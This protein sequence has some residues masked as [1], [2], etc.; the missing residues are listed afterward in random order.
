MS[1]D[2]L[3]ERRL[4]P[5]VV[6]LRLNRPQKKNALSI[7]LRDQISDTL[8]RLA[9]DESVSVVVFAAQG[10]T[11]SSG[12]DLGEF[13]MAAENPDFAAQLWA[14]SDRYHHRVLSFPVAT[15]AAV[16]GAALAGGFDLATM[17]DIRIAAR[18]ARFARPE[19][20]FGPL[21]YGPLHDLVGS[22]IA[23][24]LSLTRRS[25]DAVEAL[26]LHLVSR[27]VDDDALD[28]EA[29]AVAIA[30]AETPRDLLLRHKATMLEAT[31]TDAEA[32]TLE[33]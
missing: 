4:D 15:V 30:V 1:N 24:D 3:L 20:S 6:E 29:R 32:D 19:G 10:D 2:I 25:V 13:A 27:V 8:D 23:R 31:G 7:A 21:M 5:A 28:D 11:F 9:D 17:C 12:F 26:S 18:S 33:I 22:A 14:S 16:N